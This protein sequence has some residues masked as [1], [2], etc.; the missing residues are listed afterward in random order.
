MFFFLKK[1][2]ETLYGT[3]INFKRNKTKILILIIFIVYLFKYFNNLLLFLIVDFLKI[4]FIF[5]LLQ[6]LNY[7]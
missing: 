7:G 4:L 3:F 5:L 1:K 2:K 6:F